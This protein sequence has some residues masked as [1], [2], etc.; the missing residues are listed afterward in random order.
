MTALSQFAH[1]SPKLIGS[2]QTEP[3]P[4]TVMITYS[5]VAM[6]DGTLHGEGRGVLLTQTGARVNIKGEGIGR[7]KGSSP[8]AVSWRGNFYYVTASEALARLNSVVA[9]FEY[10]IDEDG[11]VQGSIW[12]WK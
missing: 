8:T 12:E 9:V 11:K 10:E 4:T 5:S 3:V 6:P 2:H 1:K 7:P